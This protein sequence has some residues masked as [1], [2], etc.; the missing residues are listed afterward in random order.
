MAWETDKQQMLDK[1]KELKEKGGKI[2]LAD[3]M[4]DKQKEELKN[5]PAGKFIISTMNNEVIS[6][7]DAK[8]V[9]KYYKKASKQPEI[10][11]MVRINDRS[12]SFKYT[13]KYFIIA[14]DTDSDCM[15]VNEGLG[16]PFDSDTAHEIGLYEIE[17]LSF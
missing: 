7:S 5:H 11:E 4:T 17:E 3:I 14:F 2:T 13:D 10:T 8:L 9:E 1:F 12:F 15:I 16:D 6:P